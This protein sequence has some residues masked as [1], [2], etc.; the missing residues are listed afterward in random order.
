MVNA[1]NVGE[2]DQMVLPPCHYGFQVYTRELSLKERVDYGTKRNMWRLGQTINYLHCDE[3]NI[4]TRAISLMWNQRS[5][6]TFLGL[7]FNIASY[8]LLLEIIAKAVNM[9]PDELIGN[10]G[11]THLYSNHIEQAKEQIGRKYNHEERHE[12]LKKAMGDFY[13]T[14]VDEQV[15]FGGGLSEYYDSYKIPQHSREPCKLPKLIFGKTDEFW[16]SLSEDISL[17]DH[18]DPADFTVQNYQS[19]PTIKAPLSN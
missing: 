8:G 9:V 14:A 17:F 10:L 16:K 13:Q 15:P 19:H 2:L 11:D 5:V 12:L 3:N 6:D 18:L 7:P 4:P 1:W